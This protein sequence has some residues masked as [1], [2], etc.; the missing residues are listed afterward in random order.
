MTA[1][2]PAWSQAL[3][4]DLERRHARQVAAYIERFGRPTD[5]ELERRPGPR[6]ARQARPR[7]PLTPQ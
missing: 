5:L 6:Q 7:R 4:D 1:T 2:H 3:A